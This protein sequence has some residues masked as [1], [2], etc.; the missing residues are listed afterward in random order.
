MSRVR[1]IVHGRELFCVEEQ[2][3]VADVARRMCRW[4]E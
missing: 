1:D 3:S 4:T 2:M